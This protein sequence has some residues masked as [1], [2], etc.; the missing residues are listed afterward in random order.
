MADGLDA[1]QRG[2]AEAGLRCCEEA[3][4]LSPVP[5]DATM[6]RAGMAYGQIKAGEL[7]K[8]MAALA[9]AVA[10][11]ETSNLHFTRSSWGLRL[12]EG[13]VKTGSVTARGCS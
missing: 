13:Y 8:G 3:L 10:W 11:F 9:E 2:D 12:A 6:A 1:H 7:A 5:F 4:A